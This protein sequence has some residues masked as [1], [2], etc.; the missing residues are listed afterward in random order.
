MAHLFF[1]TFYV[2]GA[3]LLVWALRTRSQQRDA[4]DWP[5][6]DGEVMERRLVEHRDGGDFTYEVQVR[7]RYSVAGVDHDGTRIAI[8]Y[9]PTDD[10]ALHEQLSDRIEV[11]R[12]LPVHHDPARPDHSVLVVNARRPLD[13]VLAFALGWLGF[14]AG[15][16]GFQAS[17]AAGVESPALPLVVIATSMIGT[18]KGGRR[19]PL[20]TFLVSNS[21]KI[22]PGSMASSARASEICNRLSSASRSKKSS[23]ARA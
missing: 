10:R 22:S 4:L 13:S 21:G 6:V 8:G 1:G 7:Y 19:P 9:G 17:L 12:T 18:T 15:I 16:H 11:G 2:I 5:S 20:S 23:L 3:A 14:T